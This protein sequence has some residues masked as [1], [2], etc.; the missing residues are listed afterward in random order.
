MFDKNVSVII[1]FTNSITITEVLS[2]TCLLAY[3][4]DKNGNH[5]K[6]KSESCSKKHKGVCILIETT[7]R[8]NGTTVSRTSIASGWSK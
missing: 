3:R 1:V 8:K 2:D 4:P 7:K 5:Y 6:L